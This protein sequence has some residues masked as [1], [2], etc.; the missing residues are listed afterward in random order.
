MQGLPRTP[1]EGQAGW[2]LHWQLSSGFVPPPLLLRPRSTTEVAFAAPGAAPALLQDRTVESLLTKPRWRS[3]IG[4]PRERLTALGVQEKHFK[5]SYGE[6][7]PL[8]PDEQG[9][10]VE[11]WMSAPGRR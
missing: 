5:M 7:L 3:S 10:Q 6:V 11:F 2:K 1:S 4:V 9:V 8:L